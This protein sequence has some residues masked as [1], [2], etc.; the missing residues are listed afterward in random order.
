MSFIAPCKVIGF[1]DALP[2]LVAL[3]PASTR[4]TF[5]RFTPLPA[6]ILTQGRHAVANPIRIPGALAPAASPSATG[7]SRAEIDLAASSGRGS[8]GRIR[9]GRVSP[10]PGIPRG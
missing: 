7:N 10:P 3:A 9:A 2:L 8:P 6:A 1:S 5:R 4:P